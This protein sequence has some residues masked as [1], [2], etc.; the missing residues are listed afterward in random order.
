MEHFDNS[1]LSQ[2]AT[3]EQ[4]NYVLVTQQLNEANKK[5]AE[6]ESEIE[7]SIRSYE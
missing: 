1:V 3:K 5:I 7:W 2:S 6:L 4:M